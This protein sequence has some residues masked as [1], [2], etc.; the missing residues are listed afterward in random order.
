MLTLS[1]WFH[2]IYNCILRDFSIQKFLIIP[3]NVRLERRLYKNGSLGPGWCDSVHQVP[4][5][6]PKGPWFDSQSGHMPGLWAPSP[7]GD[8]QEISTYLLF[9]S[10]SVSFPSPLSKNK[11][12]KYF[13]KMVLWQKHTVFALWVHNL[14]DGILAYVYVCVYFMC[15][16]TGWGKSRFTVVLIE[17]NIIINK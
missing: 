14:V 1:S 15:L 12:I 4:A 8:M 9:L 5:C 16:Y 13:L 3:R 6:K 10:L 2:W 11:Q 7:V 17:S